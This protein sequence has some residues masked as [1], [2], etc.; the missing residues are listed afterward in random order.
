MV[1]D[2]D[3]AL[4]WPEMSAPR[5]RPVFLD[6]R[7]IA[8]PLPGVLSIL[9]RISGVLLFLLLPLLL[10]LFALSLRDADGYAQVEALLAS[11][12]ARLLLLGVGWMLAH[13]LFA[14]IRYLL[15]DLDIGVERG[16]A[17]ASSWLVF[18][19]GGLSALWL[20]WMLFL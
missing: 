4:E 15:L 17:R 8:L 20:A 9:H 3:D 16:A 6:L 11:L 5:T 12:P 10:W 19:A 1:R 13:H 7:R 2:P 14:G 18:A